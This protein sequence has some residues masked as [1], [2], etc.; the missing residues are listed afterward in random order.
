[1]D[2][3][4]NGPRPGVR[5][6]DSASGAGSYTHPWRAFL[7]LA[8]AIFLTTLDL[9]VVN[10]ALPAIAVDF[11]GASLSALSWVLT[12]YAIAFAAVLVPGGQTRRS[13]RSASSLLDRDA[14][15]HRGL[16]HRRRRD[17]LLSILIAARAVQAIGAAAMTP[18][19]LG[20]ALT[21]FPPRRRA[22]VIAIW[23]AIAG[24]G[25]AAALGRRPVG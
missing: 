9:F 21:L 6:T 10:V 12:G 18:N 3:T 7:V 23:G 22:G 2:R 1:M 14:G 8:L 5:A 19:S 13:V 24:L 4:H 17:I 15:V 16:G 25:A 11:P 20:L